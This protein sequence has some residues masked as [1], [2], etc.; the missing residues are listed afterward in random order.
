MSKDTTKRINPI[1][2]YVLRLEGRSEACNMVKYLPKPTQAVF[3]GSPH[4]TDH[5]ISF[6]YNYHGN[7]PKNIR[8]S[9]FRVI[10]Q[11]KRVEGTYLNMDFHDQI[12]MSHFNIKAPSLHKVSSEDFLYLFDHCGRDKFF[13]IM[14][15]F[16]KLEEIIYR[17]KDHYEKIL[18]QEKKTIIVWHTWQPDTSN[19]QIAY[20][21]SWRFHDKKVNSFY[22]LLSDAS[23]KVYHNVF[24]YPAHWIPLSSVSDLRNI[25]Y[26]NLTCTSNDRVTQCVIESFPYL[27]H[28]KYLRVAGNIP[29]GNRTK[30]LLPA[31][32][33]M[34]RLKELKVAVTPKTD[35]D[36]RV[37]DS[38]IER[39]QSLEEL[40]ITALYN[41]DD[42]TTYESACEYIE[43]F[44]H[45][46]N[47]T[48]LTV[49][50]KP[51]CR[52]KLSKRSK[53]YLS[54]LNQ[55]KIDD[56]ET[57]Y[58]EQIYDE[59]D[60]LM[61]V[62]KNGLNLIE[63]SLD[64]GEGTT[65]RPNFG[66]FI[67][68]LKTLENIEVLEIY[69]CYISDDESL[70]ELAECLLM[71]EDLRIFAFHQIEEGVDSK[72]LVESIKRI[73]D[74]RTFDSF[75]FKIKASLID[76]TLKKLAKDANLNRCVRV[77]ESNF[78]SLSAYLKGRNRRK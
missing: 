65:H 3:F 4:P 62:L 36:N 59:R 49:V 73:T 11:V 10:K 25:K 71:L 35:R 33:S 74:G 1:F 43:S 13:Q 66:D 53:H 8:R 58:R 14:R 64:F 48:N 68:L 27:T 6:R 12:R 41:E 22:K 47:L 21:L 17:S 72:V 67:Y 69:G 24:R 9:L 45:L 26:L 31:I 60:F 34:S 19:P 78:Q 7:K 32:V 30:L 2:P 18:G 29:E 16:P 23:P 37:E 70:E 46:K 51:F 77:S 44:S 75:Y 38:V 76:D 52:K 61:N 50:L 28:V 15:A 40:D 5:P 39:L 56:P 63:L 42:D 57:V 54:Q 55:G 20:T